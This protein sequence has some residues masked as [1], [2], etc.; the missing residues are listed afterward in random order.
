MTSVDLETAIKQEEDYLRKVHPTTDDVPGCMTLFDEFLKCHSMLSEKTLNNTSSHQTFSSGDSN[1]I[2]IQTWSNVR[3]WSQERGFQILHEPK[4][5]A[6]RTETG[7]LD[8][9]SC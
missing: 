5:Y 4:I 7:R 6:P 9:P 3:M 1:K 2:V 8:P